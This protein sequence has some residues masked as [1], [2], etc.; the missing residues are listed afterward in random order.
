M[1]LMRVFN[2]EFIA[3]NSKK[4]LGPIIDLVLKDDWSTLKKIKPVFHKVYR[5]LSVT[6]TGCLL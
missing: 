5:D 4:D 6:P 3:E 1:N 2:E